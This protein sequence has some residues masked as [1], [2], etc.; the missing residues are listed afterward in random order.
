[1]KAVKN[2]FTNIEGQGDFY[3]PWG[4]LYTP[5]AEKLIPKTNR[6]IKKAEQAGAIDFTLSTGDY[7]V[8]E[9]Y[10]NCTY[11]DEGKNFPIHCVP[12]TKGFEHVIKFPVK[13]FARLWK[14]DN[15]MWHTS[16]DINGKPAASV[17]AKSW[18]PLEWRIVLSGL[19]SDICV[20]YAARG[21]LQ[22]GYKVIVLTDLVQG[23]QQE[24]AEYAA[25]N[26]AAYLATK[27]LCLMTSA[28]FIKENKGK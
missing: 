10:V 23:Y 16:A 1:M 24:M 28:Q 8:E 9:E 27:Q 18:D 11:S 22:R 3:M 25:E 26:F 2:L 20:A 14:K 7:H 21:F 15:D 19:C 6:F 4:V 12:G 13:N 17:I 5:G